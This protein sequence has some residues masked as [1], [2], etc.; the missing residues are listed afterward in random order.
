MPCW[1]DDTDENVIDMYYE[2]PKYF[3]PDSVMTWFDEY[4]Y[5]KEF[6][7]APKYH[8]V[9]CR[10]VEMKNLYN[11]YLNFWSQPRANNEGYS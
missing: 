1:I 11:G 6:H 7:T 8:E 4:E 3:I 5:H 9:S 2:E 10:F